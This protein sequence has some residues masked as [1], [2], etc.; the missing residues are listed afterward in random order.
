M[1]LFITSTTKGQWLPGDERGFVSNVKVGDHYE[2]HNQ[3]GTPVDKNVPALRRAARERMKGTPV[4]LTQEQ[5][6]V[7][8]RQFCETALRYSWKLLGA[9]VMT[10]HVHI[11]VEVPDGTN[12]DYV[13]RDLKKYGSKTLSEQFGKP[14]AGTWWTAG[15]SNKQ[16]PAEAI[17]ALL[18]YIRKQHNPLAVWI[19]PDYQ[20]PQELGTN[21]VPSPAH[22]RA[23]QLCCLPPALKNPSAHNNLQ[24]NLI[25]R[26]EV[27]RLI[28]MFFEQRDFTEVQTP[29]LSA[30]TVVDRFVEPLEIT[31]EAL[32]LNHHNNRQYFLQTSPEF[33]MKRLLAS[34]MTA[35]YQ[36]APVFRS[37]DRGRFHNTEFT[38]L[39]WYRV[40]D[41][42]QTGRKFL[43]ELVQFVTSNISFSEKSINTGI[44]F[45]TYRN[46]FEN[47]TGIN[48]HTAEPEQ[49]KQ[50]AERFKVPFPDSFTE[51]TDK[52]EWLDLLFSELV[53]KHLRNFIVYDFPASQSQLAKIR[54]VKSGQEEY[55]VSERFELFFKGLEIANGYNE[56]L[57]AEELQRRFQ[58]IAAQRQ[59]DG[60]KSLPLESRL[61]QAMESGLPQCSGT[62]LGI[63]RLLMYL[64]KADSI[65]DVMAFT[66][67]TA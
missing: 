66:V 17:P 5:A 36:I 1:F 56:L 30:D 63:E 43:A 46:V 39:E 32:P 59:M 64:L 20:T 7:L 16:K 4:F 49:L 51:N 45:S 11:F 24:S 37:G 47:Y 31:N 34:G 3:Y 12:P 27:L 53:Q 67:E 40:G 48:P 44:S 9:A 18:N 60:K 23:A 50:T 52:D 33:A 10:N 8:M 62:A 38:M 65:E 6:D 57:D 25:R 41:D 35:I 42:Y 61:I 28:R 14:A 2:I 13:S 19:H 15:C 22:R 54:L 55:L 26:S 58:N 29:V 21:I